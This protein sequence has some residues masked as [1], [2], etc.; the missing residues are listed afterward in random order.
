MWA[1]IP[2]FLHESLAG[3]GIVD[4]GTKASLLGFTVIGVGSIG[5]WLGGA[6]ADRFGR[7][8]V[9]VAAMAVSGGC[10]AVMGWLLAASLFVLVPIVLIWGVTVI[11]DSAQFSA[12][13]AELA[14]SNS[15][16]TLLT[17]QTCAGFLLTT[18][19]IHLIGPVQ[20][21]IGWPGAFT[22]L[23]MGPL[24]GCIAMWRLRLHPDAS[25]LSGGMR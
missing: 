7:T 10:A 18:I 12:A 11:A 9:T 5:A 15:V 3:R 6:L 25:R 13:V 14:D 19:S 4:A 2:V 24:I 1:W 16:G 22:M 23:A 8:S 20:A 17:I 21:A